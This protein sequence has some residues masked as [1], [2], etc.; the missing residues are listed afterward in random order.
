MLSEA[1]AHVAPGQQMIGPKYSFRTNAG[2]A[3][4]R[5]ID[6][7]WFIVAKNSVTT[8]KT[9]KS[10]TGFHKKSDDLVWNFC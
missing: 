2:L 8:Q 5:M 1:S 6:D 3:S 4:I 10:L 9:S 7:A